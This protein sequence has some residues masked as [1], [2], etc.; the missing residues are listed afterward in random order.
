MR[1]YPPN[2]PQAAARIVAL[3]LLAD[4]HVCHSELELLQRLDGHAQLG[5]SP[6]EMHAVVHELCEDMLSA[7]PMAWGGSCQVDARTLDALLAEVT[8]P[9][10][11]A[12]VLN[13]CVS[14]VESDDHVSDGESL[15]LVSAIEQWGLQRQVLNGGRGQPRR[16]QPA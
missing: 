8:D 3:A 6:A 7:C 9:M 14:L 4:G 16:L 12:R 15:L 13:L 2:S 10:L 1:S 11:R 5:L